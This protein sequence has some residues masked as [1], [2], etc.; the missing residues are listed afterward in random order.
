MEAE[1]NSAIILYSPRNGTE[2]LNPKARLGSRWHTAASHST[3]EVKA[4]MTEGSPLSSATSYC[5]GVFSSRCLLL[6]SCADAKIPLRLLLLYF[7]ERP[8]SF[9]SSGLVFN[10]SFL[11]QGFHNWQVMQNLTTYAQEAGFWGITRYLSQWP[12]TDSSTAY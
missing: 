12:Q 1:S 4:L 10:L 5:A 11:A 6:E 3:Q 7:F 8:P 2:G 9:S